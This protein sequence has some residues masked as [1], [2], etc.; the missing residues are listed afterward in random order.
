M[1]DEISGTLMVSWGAAALRKWLNK[2]KVL[3]CGRSWIFQNITVTI[4]FSNPAYTLMANTIPIY[5]SNDVFKWWSSGECNTP[6]LSKATCVCNRHHWI[7]MT[8]AETEEVLR[9]Y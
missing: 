8:E 4:F 5:N 9:G 3:L 6:G 1:I 7:E 2:Q